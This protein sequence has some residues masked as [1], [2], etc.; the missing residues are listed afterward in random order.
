LKHFRSKYDA[1]FG[2]SHTILKD[3]EFVNKK[4][5]MDKLTLGAIR[6]C[7]MN[8]DNERIFSYIELLN[9]STSLKLCIQL[10][11]QL[12]ASEL[13]QKIA[14]LVSEKEQKD[15]MMETY[16]S[17][18]PQAALLSGL[19]NRRMLKTAISSGD[20]PDL[21]SHSLNGAPT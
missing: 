5:E 15:L 21:S 3:N 1:E 16:K 20:R 11:D 13:S 2:L 17:S 18:R 19:D 12:N 4:K 6:L 10:R 8:N 9:F 14:K 7:I